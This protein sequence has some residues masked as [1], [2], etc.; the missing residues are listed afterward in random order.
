MGL[1]GGQAAVRR[2][3]A[4]LKASALNLPSGRAGSEALAGQHTIGAAASLAAR[5]D[6]M[7]DSDQLEA[8]LSD[9]ATVAI[10]DQCKIDKPVWW[11]GDEDIVGLVDKISVKRKDFTRDEKYLGDRF[12]GENP[13]AAG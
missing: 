10:I 2:A 5:V 7:T 6:E 4:V 9:G 13:L 12:A 1:L 11:G 8:L 3:E